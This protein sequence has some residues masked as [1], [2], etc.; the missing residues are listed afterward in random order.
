MD[1]KSVK[2]FSEIWGISTER[3]RKFCQE[4]R[5]TGTKKNGKCW[6][7]PE[8]SEKPEDKRF[9]KQYDKLFEKI[10]RHK[11]D[12]NN[13]FKENPPLSDIEQKCLR[14]KFIIENTYNT[15]AIEGNT[16][17]LQETAW[18]LEDITIYKKSLREHMELI[19][20]KDAFEW[21]ET[22]IKEDRPISTK[23]IKD[24]HSLVL[25]GRRQDAGVYRRIPVYI[26]GSSYI[27]IKPY[28]IESEMR[29]L[30]SK[31]KILHK[32]KHIIECI[33][34]FHLI[35][36]GIHPFI[37]GNGVTGRLLINYELMRNKYLPIDIKYKDVAR[38]Y[39]AFNIY[40]KS[41]KRDS[42]AMVKL[43]AEYVLD[44]LETFKK[45]IT[46]KYF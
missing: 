20:H 37:V 44:T 1:Y 15:N 34:I 40:Q 14:K 39:K 46:D 3:I 42:S 4:G 27:P 23:L 43:I 7:I 33:S 32:S 19:G 30:I 9:S 17:T 6:L 29:E 21:I 28:L 38:Y 41:N 12:I 16:M 2:E 35:F 5:I 11:N 8:N 31:Y 26:S 22:N 36:E 45:I 24:I 25:M 13:W 10:D 18:V